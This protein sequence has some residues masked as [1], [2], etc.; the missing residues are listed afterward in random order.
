IK[1]VGD[2]VTVKLNGELVTDN[3]V[4]ENVW[5]RDKP[6]YPRGQIELQNHGNQLWFR[7]IYI[8]ELDKDAQPREAAI[9]PKDEPIRLFNG[10]N[11]DGFY[12]YIEDT[13]YEDPRQVFTVKDGMIHISGDGFGGLIT[14]KEYRDYHL[15]IEFKWG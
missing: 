4:M 5:E 8:R 10:K 9:S 13:G 1:M 2:R 12:T 15:V 14:D 7:N 6:I 3:V 11:L